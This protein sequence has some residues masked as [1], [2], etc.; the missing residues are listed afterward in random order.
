MNPQLALQRAEARGRKLQAKEDRARAR[1][2]QRIHDR[3][4]KAQRELHTACVEL[5]DYY[6]GHG[7]GLVDYHTQMHISVATDRAGLALQ[8]M[9][10]EYPAITFSGD[11]VR[12]PQN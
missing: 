12:R 11:I 3:L 6:D 8:A 9:R 1:S 4:T 5:R 10:A 2:R 7:F